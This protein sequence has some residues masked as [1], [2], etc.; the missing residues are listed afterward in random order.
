M[1][2]KDDKKLESFFGSKS[3]IK[4]EINIKGTLKIDGI[5]TGQVNADY[6]ILGESAFVKGDIAAKNV[7]VGGKLEGNLKAEE[8]VEIKSKGKVY[9]E[10]YTKKFSV[11]EGG[12]FNG[13]IVMKMD[14]S[15]ILEFEAKK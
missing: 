11:I 3:D 15:K 1:L 5:V 8:M 14:E 4:G 2:L 7:V 10:I 9:G 6:V 13:K 12:E